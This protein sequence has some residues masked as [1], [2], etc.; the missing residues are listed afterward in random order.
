[1]RDQEPAAA[2]FFDVMQA[3]TGDMPGKLTQ[4]EAHVAFHRLTKRIVV[5]QFAL[6][7][8]TSHAKRCSWNLNDHV[9]ER[10]VDAN[11]RQQISNTLNA[12]GANLNRPPILQCLGNT[13]QSSVDEIDVPYRLASTVDLLPAD[14]IHWFR[15]P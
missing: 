12:N 5:L 3:T 9:Q 2:S 10:S 11:K 15:N 8:I 6:H 1:M 7:D 13:D 4:A 14:Q